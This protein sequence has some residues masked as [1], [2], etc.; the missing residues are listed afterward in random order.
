MAKLKHYLV[1]LLGAACLGTVAACARTAERRG[2][3][4]VVDDATLTARVEPA[5][6]QVGGLRSC[7][8]AGTTHRGEVQVRGFLRDEDLRKRAGEPLRTVPGVVRV[9]SDLR[10][11]PRR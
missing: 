8:I 9:Y 2:T 4:E 5:L 10:V 1:G 7:S 3:G 6:V 11:A